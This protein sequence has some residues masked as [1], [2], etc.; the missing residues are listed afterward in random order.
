M[1]TFAMRFAFAA[2]LTALAAAAPLPASIGA[3]TM[4]PDGTISLRLRAESAGGAIGEGML[5]YRPGTPRYDEV[6]RHLGGL[7]PGQTK[8]IPP[9][10]D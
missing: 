1:L 5:T 9:W 2:I 4:A 8:P 6:L 7:K 3:A 10:K